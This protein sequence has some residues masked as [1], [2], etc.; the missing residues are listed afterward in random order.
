MSSALGH[1]VDC[2][3]TI[4]S[5]IPF[6]GDIHV[7]IIPCVDA[8]C[9]IFRQIDFGIIQRQV[10]VGFFV[11]ILTVQIHTD[12]NAVAAGGQVGILDCQVNICAL[13]HLD[14]GF[15]FFGI[16]GHFSRGVSRG[17]GIHIHAVNHDGCIFHTL[18]DRDGVSR[19]GLRR[20]TVLCVVARSIGGLCVII[21]RY[22]YLCAIVGVISGWR[23]YF[24]RVAVLDVDHTIIR[25]ILI[26]VGA[27]FIALILTLITE[28]TAI[29]ILIN[30]Y[31]ATAQ[32]IRHRRST[33]A[34]RAHGNRSSQRHCC[35]LEFLV[36][37]FSSAPFQFMLT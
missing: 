1:F 30:S 15:I 28:C 2:F 24:W 31:T 9:G 22:G 17:T 10:N 13:A 27:V 32:I 21:R 35:Q 7:G 16:C 26:D 37:H 34:N 29:L 14:D 36:C 19:C 11:L 3:R 25:C 6:K 4:N 18:F 5:I 12:I 33:G 20:G 8:R 23:D